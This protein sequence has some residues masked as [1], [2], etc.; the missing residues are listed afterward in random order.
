M[1]LSQERIK[2]AVLLPQE[3]FNLLGYGCGGLAIAG[4]SSV[5]VD[6]A[7]HFELANADF[8]SFNLPDR[9][10]QLFGG[11]AAVNLLGQQILNDFIALSFFLVIV[12]S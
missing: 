4:L 10:V 12:M 3:F 1:L 11:F 7:F 9:Q 6:H 5:A 2:I 8:D